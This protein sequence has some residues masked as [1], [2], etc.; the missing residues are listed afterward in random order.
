[1]KRV[2]VAGP[3]SADTVMGVLQNI[4]R[5]E[6]TAA[7]LFKNGFSPFCPWH[8]KDYVISMYYEYFTAQRFKDFSMAWLEVSDAVYLVEGWE[9][10]GGTLE[11]IKRAKELGIP[12]FTSLIELFRWREETDNE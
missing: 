4:G 8:D 10:S 11:E 7:Y 5:G 6:S 9:K 3:Y 12:V 1:M 2:Y